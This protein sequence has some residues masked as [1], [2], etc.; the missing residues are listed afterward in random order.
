MLDPGD[1][2]QPVYLIQPYS[3]RYLGVIRYPWKYVQHER[4]GAEYL[5]NL[6]DDPGENLNRSGELSAAERA[7]WQREIGKLYYHQKL[8]YHDAI[9]PG[10]EPT[11]KAGAVTGK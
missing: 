1:A 2:Q 11:A 5:F 10:G 3:G 7:E 6:A 9:W 8:I 4:S